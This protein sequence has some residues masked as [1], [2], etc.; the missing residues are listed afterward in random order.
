MTAKKP[1]LKI[2]PEQLVQ[3]MNKIL[4]TFEKRLNALEKAKT[5]SQRPRIDKPL[6]LDAQEFIIDMNIRHIM[7]IPAVTRKEIL[8]EVGV[9]MKKYK[10]LELRATLSRKFQRS[11]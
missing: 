5:Q 10:I 8:N 7:P 1:K 11:F 4:K 6:I 3:E 9:L 2:T